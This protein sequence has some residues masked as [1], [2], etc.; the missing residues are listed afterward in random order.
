[1]PQRPDERLSPEGCV[2]GENREAQE[3]RNE[4][5]AVPERTALESV[6]NCMALRRRL[7]YSSRGR[8]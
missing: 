7:V 3:K 1:M 8:S 2:G 6:Q 5:S 4:T